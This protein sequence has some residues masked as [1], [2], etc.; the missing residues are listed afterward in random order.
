MAAMWVAFGHGAAAEK[1]QLRE[2]IIRRYL[3]VGGPLLAVL[4]LGQLWSDP[5]A[6]NK[7]LQS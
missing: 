3:R 6:R 5:A 2:Y 4:L 7:P 1:I